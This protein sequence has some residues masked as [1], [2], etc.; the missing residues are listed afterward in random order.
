MILIIWG[1]SLR[2][3][4]LLDL[5]TWFPTV[6]SVTGSQCLILMRENLIG[7]S[8]IHPGNFQ[9]CPKGWSHT[10]HMEGCLFKAV[11]WETFQRRWISGTITPMVPFKAIRISTLN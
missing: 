7:E 11:G 9:L 4:D 2:M 1:H 10:V 3:I 5:H 8:D 6:D